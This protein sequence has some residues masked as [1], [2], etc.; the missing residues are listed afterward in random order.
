MANTFVY[1]PDLIV[2]EGSTQFMPAPSS[3]SSLQ[4]IPIT[5]G[6]N[7]HH[8]IPHMPAAAEAQQRV[9]TLECF[10]NVSQDNMLRAA[11]AVPAPITK[12]RKIGDNKIEVTLNVPDSVWQKTGGEQMYRLHVARAW[13]KLDGL[14][15]VFPGLLD[16]ALNA[17]A[18]D[19]LIRVKVDKTTGR[20]MLKTRFDNDKHAANFIKLMGQQQSAF[21]RVDVA[22]NDKGFS[23]TVVSAPSSVIY[24][25]NNSL[26]FDAKDILLRDGYEKTRSV[27]EQLVQE[28][29]IRRPIIAK[30]LA[31]HRANGEKFM[32]I[33]FDEPGN[34]HVNRKLRRSATESANALWRKLSV[35]LG[36]AKKDARIIDDLHGRMSLLISENALV[37]IAQREAQ[38]RDPQGVSTDFRLHLPLA[39]P[40]HHV[41]NLL[42]Q[43][44][45][46]G[47]QEGRV[48]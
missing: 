29:E 16:G 35:K 3:S 28:Q 6:R 41:A 10:E 9:L 43:K 39:E 1:N 40:G 23:H 26:E 12:A 36:I 32:R 17:E 22:C 42:A 25:Q 38:K 47:P 24:M 4:S 46:T 33:A 15:T 48:A 13:R 34:G 30:E 11:V 14:S 8:A 27:I 20:Y 19:Q 37:D 5:R 7:E 31:A 2:P 18:R 45:E 21:W 44:E